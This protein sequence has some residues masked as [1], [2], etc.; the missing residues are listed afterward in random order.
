MVKG[1]PTRRNTW[2]CAKATASSCTQNGPCGAGAEKK[3]WKESHKLLAT[4]GEKLRVSP[5]RICRSAGARHGRGRSGRRRSGPG[6]VSVNEAAY[7]GLV[8]DI[9][10]EPQYRL[11]TNC[12]FAARLVGFGT[13]SRN[14]ATQEISPIGGLVCRYW[15]GAPISA[16]TNCRFAARLIGFGTG[17]RNRLPRKYRR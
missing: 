4:L 2:T 8:V 15:G 17:S 10:A 9:G 16:T 3:I 13:G 6:C 7:R 5:W 11:T 14:R 1:P 12:R